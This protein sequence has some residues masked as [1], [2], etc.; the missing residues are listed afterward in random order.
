MGYKIVDHADVVGASPVSVAPTT[1][2]FS[3]YIYT[4]LVHEM[5][6]CC[7]G[8]SHY[9]NQYWQNSL[10]GVTKGQWISPAER[11]E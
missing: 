1:P 4:T 2:S 8:M 10:Y 6:W 7:Q 5:A 3:T 9:L 11:L